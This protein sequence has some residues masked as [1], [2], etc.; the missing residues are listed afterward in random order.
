[1]MAKLSFAVV[2][3]LVLGLK[4]IDATF[5]DLTYALNNQTVTFPGRVN[6]FNVEFE[7]YTDSGIW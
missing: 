4:S 3:T 6:R 2:L 5:V 1:M 7:G